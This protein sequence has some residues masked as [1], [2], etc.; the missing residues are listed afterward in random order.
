MTKRPKFFGRVEKLS[1]KL[2]R[3]CRKWRPIDFEADL[4]MEKSICA[5]GVGTDI[6]NK[7][8]MNIA[9]RF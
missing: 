4:G 2:F 7:T 8:Y 6:R 9:V 1:V 3:C 5:S